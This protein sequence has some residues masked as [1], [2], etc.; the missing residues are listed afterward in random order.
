MFKEKRLHAVRA[1]E[2][3]LDLLNILAEGS[4]K[5]QIGTLAHKLQIGRN[6]VLLLL[7]TLES[8]GMVEWDDRSKIYRPGWKAAELAQT[9]L[10][11]IEDGSIAKKQCRVLR[12]ELPSSTPPAGRQAKQGNGING[13]HWRRTGLISPDPAD[14]A[15]ENF[16]SQEEFK[17]YMDSA[18]I[19]DLGKNRGIGQK[20]FPE[21][22]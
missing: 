13:L 9:L 18:A 17:E 16:N 20:G 19:A 21:V 5:L 15:H 3:T 12:K 14:F 10:G 1:T 7:V 6:E 4:E 2:K 8:R 22:I 11:R